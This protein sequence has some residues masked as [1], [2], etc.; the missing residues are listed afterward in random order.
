MFML[1]IFCSLRNRPMECKECGW[2]P[3]KRDPNGKTI[4][5]VTCYA[6]SQQFTFC[7]KRL[8]INY[9]YGHMAREC[10]E[11]QNRYKACPSTEWR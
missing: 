10:K 1:I 6:S 4:E 5:Y 9:Y 3:V 11:N 7:L 2:G 8:V